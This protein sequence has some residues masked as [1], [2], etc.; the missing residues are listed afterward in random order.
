M[1]WV[2][3]KTSQGVEILNRDHIERIVCNNRSSTVKVFL[4]G[5]GGHIYSKDN[6]PEILGEVE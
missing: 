6:L 3:V 4:A 2:K 5:G 1:N